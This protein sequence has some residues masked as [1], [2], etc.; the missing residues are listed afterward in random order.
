MPSSV[1]VAV[2]VPY[3]DGSDEFAALDASIRA[4]GAQVLIA[5]TSNARDKRALAS[6]RRRQQRRD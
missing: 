4:C 2:T 3:E 5:N 6:L 1:A